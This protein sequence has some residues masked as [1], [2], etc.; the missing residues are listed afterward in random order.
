[1]ERVSSRP[2]D[3]L[4]T[5]GS[6]V[7]SLAHHT[8]SHGSHAR[9][10]RLRC[11]WPHLL[12]ALH[13]LQEPGICAISRLSDSGSPLPAGQPRHHL[14]QRTAAGLARRNLVIGLS[15]YGLLIFNGMLH[16]GATIATGAAGAGG[17]LT[18]GLLFIP[19]F[20]WMI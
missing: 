18:G 8:D 6:H 4:A 12:P 2:Y 19:S 3:Q 7:S 9:G 11:S 14:G 20:F 10:V 5:M 13:A 15:W 16:F 17:V 1:M